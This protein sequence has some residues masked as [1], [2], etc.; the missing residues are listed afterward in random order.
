MFSGKAK[1]GIYV[2]FLGWLLVFHV[3][4][5]FIALF[6]DQSLIYEKTGLLKGEYILSYITHFGI[7]W[8]IIIEMARI[9]LA[10]LMTYLMIWVVPSLVNE[11]SYKKE[12]EAEYSLRKMKIKKDEEL[13]QKEEKVVKKQMENIEAEKKVVVEKS[14]LEDTPKFVLWDVDFQN[15]KYLPIFNEFEEIISCI[16]EYHGEPGNMPSFRIPSSRILAYL[17]SNGVLDIKSGTI[18]LTDKGRYFVKKYTEGL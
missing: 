7:W 2:T 14:K 13:N 12:L 16:Y 1:T 9:S 8:T 6:L 5:I 15:F 3:D 11:K 10:A 18:S 17:N 4:V